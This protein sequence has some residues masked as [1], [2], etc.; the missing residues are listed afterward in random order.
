MPFMADDVPGRQVRGQPDGQNKQHG[1]LAF[2]VS[3]SIAKDSKNKA[4][5]WTLLRYLVGQPGM[6]TWT[7]KGLA[8]P[9]RTRRQA[10]SP[11]AE[12]SSRRRR[13]RT[14]WQFAPTLH[15]GDRHVA[16]NELKAVIEGKQTVDGML[17]KVQSA[18]NDAL[19]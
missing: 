5:A 14:P 17:K 6:G 13:R 9:S 3:Y 1:N 18:A 11:V 12:R 7:S 10:A 19:C 4:A 16:N 2:T 15:Q 8:L